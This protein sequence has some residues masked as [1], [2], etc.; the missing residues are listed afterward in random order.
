MIIYENDC[1]G[2]GLP[3]LG[4][5]CPLTHVPH[6]YCDICGQDI[7]EEDIY[8]EDDGYIICNNCHEEEQ[9]PDKED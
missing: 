6:Y 2:C 5:S 9:Q 8:S 4:S 7:W 3:C 1:V